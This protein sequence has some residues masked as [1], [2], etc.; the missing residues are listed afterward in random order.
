MVNIILESKNDVHRL[1]QKLREACD[2]EGI[3]LGKDNHKV[4][5]ILSSMLGFRDYNTL[6]GVAANHE[7][8]A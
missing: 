2:S 6:L 8:S 1:R 4:D 3:R 7:E 5:K